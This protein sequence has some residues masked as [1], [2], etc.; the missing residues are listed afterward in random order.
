[1]LG[2]TYGLLGRRDAALRHGEWAVEL[3]PVEKDALE[4]PTFLGNL[5]RLR[6]IVGEREEALDLLERV[7]SMPGR[8]D[9]AELR[10]DPGWEPIRDHPRF[11]ALL[12]EAGVTW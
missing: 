9:P 6:A 7:L 12:E 3:F 8:L 4:G 10:Y 5:A 2:E 11:R 1:M